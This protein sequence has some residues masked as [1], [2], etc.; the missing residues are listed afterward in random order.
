MGM[1]YVLTGVVV[2]VLVVAGRGQEC[3]WM[4]RVV[5]HRVVMLKK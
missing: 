1:M 5:R 2:R 4:V 3:G